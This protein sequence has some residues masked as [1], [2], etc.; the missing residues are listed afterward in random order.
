[1]NIFLKWQ[2]NKNSRGKHLLFLVIGALIFP[3]LIP[4]VLVIL[5]PQVDKIIGIASFYNGLINI[6]VGIIAI[7]MGGFI[8]FSTIIAKNGACRTV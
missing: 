3:I 2:N 6:I 7:I 5:L 4:T 1:M 8:A